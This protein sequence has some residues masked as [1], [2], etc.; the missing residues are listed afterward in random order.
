[1]PD[2]SCYLGR[3]ARPRIAVMSGAARATVANPAAAT[4]LAS[5]QPTA[6]LPVG[7]NDTSA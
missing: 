3:P 4:S 5:S 1:M 7:G 6:Q 2:V